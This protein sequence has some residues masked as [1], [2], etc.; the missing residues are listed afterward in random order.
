MKKRYLNTKT[1]FAASK[2][3]SWTLTLLTSGAGVK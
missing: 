3:F 1:L 2:P